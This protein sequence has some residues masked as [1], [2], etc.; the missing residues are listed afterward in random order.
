MSDAPI[1]HDALRTGIF[2]GLDDA[3]VD[4]L[5]GTAH[6]LAFGAGEAI[7]DAGDRGDGMFVVTSGEARVDVGGRFHLL[8]PGD[9]FGE[10]AVIAPGPRMA[11][12]KAVTD[13]ETLKIDADDFQAFLLAHPKVALSILK[14][15]VLRLREVEQRIDAW[16]A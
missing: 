6:P 15:V 13:V 5:L 12:V 1:Q 3:D 16:M 11:T 4:G 10:M 7:F 9:F 2:A 14:A 8:K